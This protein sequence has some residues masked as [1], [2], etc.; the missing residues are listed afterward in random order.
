[1]YSAGGIAMKRILAITFL[2]YFISGALTLAIPLLLLDRNVD[3]VEIGIVISVLP[4]VFMVVRLLMAAIA[5][6]KGWNRF[7]LLMNWPWSILSTFVYFIASSTPMFLLG[8]FLEALKESSYWAVSRTAIFSLSPKREEKAA[9]RNI[10][11]LMLSTAVGSAVAG[12]GIANFGFSLTFSIL[13]VAAGFIAIPAALLW[14]IPKQNFKQNNRRFREILHIRRKGRMFWLVSITSVFF[15]LAFFPL[16]NLL[17]P[18]FMVQQIGYDYLTVGI[19]YM[20]Y[21]LI[22]SIVILGTLKFS[23]GFK[24]VILQSSIALFSTFLLASSNYYVFAL[25][26]ALAVAEGLGWAFYESIIAKAT[27]D[28]PS[29]SVDIGLLIAPLR[30]AEFGSVLYAGVIAQNLGYTPVFASSG[31]FFL[32]FSVLAFYLLRT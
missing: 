16:S 18:V 25:F 3:L 11:V 12:F 17:I 2:N 14:K 20:L 22:A 13:I 4:I 15:S 5:D 29:V 30:F 31:I 24:R 9:T 19:A 27:K 8:K 21:N 28:K 6:S 10:A 32:I 23:L 7:Y 26:L 1:V